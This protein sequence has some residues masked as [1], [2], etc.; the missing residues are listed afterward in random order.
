MLKH[1][2]EVASFSNIRWLLWNT[3]PCS[4][5]TE[6]KIDFV[7]S[8]ECAFHQLWWINE[9]S[10]YYL[11]LM[12]PLFSLVLWRHSSFSSPLPWRYLLFCITTG[13][14]HVYTLAIS[15]SPQQPIVTS[16]LPISLYQAGMPYC[17]R[18]LLICQP[19]LDLS[20]KT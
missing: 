15:Y 13:N 17:L 10:W 7:H 1:L 19:I 8:T 2:I 5:C 9:C 12:F 6:N 4:R 11:L 18:T 20:L 16:I 3:L 14:K